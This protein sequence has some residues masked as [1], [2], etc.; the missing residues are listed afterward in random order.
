MSM[1]AMS[2]LVPA[3][4]RE[5]AVPG[6]FPETFPSTT[7]EDL[8]QSL[9]DGFA[10][11]QLYGFFPDL[12]LTSSTDPVSNEVDWET[13]QELSGSG[14]ALV[15][16]FTSMRFIR[17]SLRGI[18]TSERYKAGPAEFEIQ[19]SANLLR[20]ELAFLKS[21]LDDLINGAKAAARAASTVMVFDGYLA[22][23]GD[24][25]DTGGLYV[26]EYRG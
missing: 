9:A 8:T 20:D 13:S 3:L 22:R 11:A 17:A 19:R 24:I 4:K 12:T 16:I 15:V 18:L 26:Y 10:E 14:A 21:R 2:T 25:T 7:D 23:G 6:T 5:L 1:T